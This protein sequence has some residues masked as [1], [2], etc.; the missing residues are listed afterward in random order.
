MQVSSFG[1]T[2]QSPS[3]VATP[4]T[5]TVYFPRPANSQAI[6]D[7][8]TGPSVS[9]P[10][11]PVFIASSGP[12]VSNA[13]GQ[14]P[15]PVPAVFNVNNGMRLR[16][17]ASGT[18]T[19][20][21][22]LATTLT[23][24]ANTGTLASPAYTTL[25]TAANTPGAAGTFP[26]QLEGHFVIGGT[27]FVNSNPPDAQ[28]S[29]GLITQGQLV[30]FYLGSINGVLVDLAIMPATTN[31][32]SWGQSGFVANATFGTGNAGNSATLMQFQIVGD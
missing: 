14:V 32:A 12:T 24:Q 5:S 11:L 20:G 27:T 18:F 30:G 3:I 10:G 31:P 22:S 28:A 15:L 21:A 26:W 23:V 17:M 1:V 13:T 4:G 7:G 9:V 25:M 2:G 6:V 8:I 29:P 16:I 19:V